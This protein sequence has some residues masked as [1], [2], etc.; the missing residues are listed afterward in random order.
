MTLRFILGLLLGFLL[1]ASIA[2][3]FAPQSGAETRHKVWD[4]SRHEG[5]V[6]AS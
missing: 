2:L 5:D 1:G 6:G 3:A 4:R